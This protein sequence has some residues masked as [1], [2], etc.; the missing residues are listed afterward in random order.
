MIDLARDQILGEYFLNSF[1]IKCNVSINFENMSDSDTYDKLGSFFH[2]YIHFLQ[3]ASTTYGN[4]N[5]GNFYAKIM[6][7]LYGIQNSQGTKISRLIHYN[8]DIEFADDICNI[9]MGDA[10]A[11]TY[12]NYDYIKIIDTVFKYDEALG[13][14]YEQAMIPVLR[15]QLFKKGRTEIREFSF[16]A[17]A[18]ME[19]MASLIERH[20]YNKDFMG[21][22]LQYDICMILWNYFVPERFVDKAELVLA[23]CEYSLMYDNPGSIFYGI[24]KCF[25]SKIEKD[26]IKI[27][28]IESI[29]KTNI[30][31]N[32]EE[33][34]KHYY[35]EMNR[36]FC[37]L[38]P[39]E[40]SFCDSLNVYV[41]NFCNKLF[42]LRTANSHFLADLMVMDSFN[43]RRE[44]VGIMNKT[45]AIPLIIS[46][47]NELY[48]GYEQSNKMGMT[49]YLAL[50]SFKGLFGINGKNQ[51]YMYEICKAIDNERVDDRC[52]YCPWEKA[53]ENELCPMAQI[54]HMWKLVGK[55]IVD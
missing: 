25:I 14:E 35:K 8:Q 28:D 40:N 52:V 44:L 12:D 45:K 20:L 51:C 6:G 1:V 3:N 39:Y 10:E 53:D 19:S 54:W 4:I 16:G 41:R 22:Q 42:G 43:A 31:P 2:E 15:L 18:I 24:V 27:S 5:M 33:T 11:W 48:S 29:F 36:L 9:T 49:N 21:T 37:D 50:Y 55:R 47:K 26:E 46:N 32:F 38:V 34:Y 13:K 17:M 23:M 30:K 7:I